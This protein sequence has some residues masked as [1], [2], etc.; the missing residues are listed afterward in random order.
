MRQSSPQCRGYVVV[1]A[2]AIELPGDKAG[3]FE[4]DLAVFDIRILR[5]V[6]ASIF[7]VVP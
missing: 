1:C 6:D 5:I 4:R 3:K 2:N 7:P